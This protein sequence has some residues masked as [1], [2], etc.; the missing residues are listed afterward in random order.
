MSTTEQVAVHSNEN[1]EDKIRVLID[2]ELD[3]VAGGAYRFVR[4][5]AY[6]G[7]GETTNTQLWVT[8]TT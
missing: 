2:E 8:S 6:P 5:V 1:E 4:A 3:F 7:N